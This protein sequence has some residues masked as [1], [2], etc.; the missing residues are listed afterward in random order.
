MPGS[1]SV[2]LAA[3][4]CPVMVESPFN[5]TTT[6]KPLEAMSLKFWFTADDSIV[7][8]GMNWFTTVNVWPEYGMVS[9]YR[10]FIAGT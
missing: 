2:P 6:D 5:F 9:S 1:A 4:N 8:F 3:L 10:L 7:V